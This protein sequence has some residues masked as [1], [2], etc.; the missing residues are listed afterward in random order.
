VPATAQFACKIRT[1]HQKTTNR[2]RA[3]PSHP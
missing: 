3:V 2:V 1:P